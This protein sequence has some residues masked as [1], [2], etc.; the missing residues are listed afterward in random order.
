[1]LLRKDQAR[2]T[3]PREKIK[4]LNYSI[5]TR[6][7]ALDKDDLATP[8]RGGPVGDGKEH[9]ARCD[10]IVREHQDQDQRRRG[11]RGSGFAQAIGALAYRG[12]TGSL[13][14]RARTTPGTL[15][16]HPEDTDVAEIVKKLEPE[17]VP[18]VD[19]VK[20]A[21]K[22]AG[23]TRSRRKLAGRNVAQRQSRAGRFHHR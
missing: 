22:P 1:M 3:I 19:P 8:R 12:T 5:G 10:Q 20:A 4:S 15:R 18:K 23:R 17:V 21:A 13:T 14:R 11:R 6:L 7:G 9:V 16:D 2:I